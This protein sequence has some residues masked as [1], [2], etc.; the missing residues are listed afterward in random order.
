M[1]DRMHEA[2]RAYQATQALRAARQLVHAAR[3]RARQERPQG[4]GQPDVDASAE[5]EVGPRVEVS[6]VG[7]ATDPLDVGRPGVVDDGHWQTRDR[8]EGPAEQLVI[9]WTKDGA[10]ARLE[11]DLA[12][13]TF[14]IT[15]TDASG[16]ERELR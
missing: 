5:A 13:A 10:S 1:G 11:A 7:L 3:D 9:T 12:S 8:G 15:A 2:L 16:S 4:E 14:R 6:D